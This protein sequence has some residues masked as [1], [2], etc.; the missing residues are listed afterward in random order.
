MTNR[1]YSQSDYKNASTAIGGNISELQLITSNIAKAINTFNV[2]ATEKLT[3]R[4]F[5]IIKQRLIMYEH[6]F[7]YFSKVL[8]LVVES[9]NSSNSIIIQSLDAGGYETISDKLIDELKNQLSLINSQISSLTPTKF[10]KKIFQSKNDKIQLVSYN[11]TADNINQQ[12]RDMFAKL[13]EI[14]GLDNSCAKDVNEITNKLHV[15]ES[16]N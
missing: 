1:Y 5:D 16:G 14:S 15:L 2:G 12:I 7:E 11:N 3:G 6:S 8:E 4:A 13:D 10:F 9:V